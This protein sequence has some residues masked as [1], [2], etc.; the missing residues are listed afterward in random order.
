MKAVLWQLDV[1]VQRAARIDHDILEKLGVLQ[2]EYHHPNCTRTQEI[3]EAA[4]FLGFDALIVPSARWNC[5][6]LVLFTEQ[7]EPEHL[8]AVK[9]EDVDWDAWRRTIKAR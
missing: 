4:A 9:S 5:S 8:A 6:N 2:S 7:I 3:G 1:K